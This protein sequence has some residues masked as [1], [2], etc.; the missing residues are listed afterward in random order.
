MKLLI[1]YRNTEGQTKKI[2]EYIRDKAEGNDH[3]ATS[4][5]Y[6]IDFYKL[7]YIYFL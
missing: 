7:R 6:L 5:I 4:N 1:V 3:E 2:C